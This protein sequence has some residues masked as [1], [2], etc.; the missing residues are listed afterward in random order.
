MTYSNICINLAIFFHI[1]SCSTD[2]KNYINHL[3]LYFSIIFLFNRYEISINHIQ[4]P[5]IFPWI[6]PH[7]HGLRQIAFRCVV[8]V[9]L[10][11]R[12][13]LLDSQIAAQK[14]ETEAAMA[15]LREASK[16]MEAI[17]FEKCPGAMVI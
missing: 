14:Q 2:I 10:K 8:G 9:S 13:A 3:F 4:S 12:Q 7:L 1:K 17:Q 5:S 16:E 11:N 6:F 15:T